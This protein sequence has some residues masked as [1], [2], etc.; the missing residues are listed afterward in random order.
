MVLVGAT[1][2][3]GRALMERTI[4]VRGIRLAAIAR[5]RIPLPT[6]ARMEMFVADT[7]HWAETMQALRPAV[8]VCALGTTW[9][10]AGKDEAAFRAVDEELVLHVARMA[11]EAGVRQFILVSSAGADR[12]SRHLYLRVKG[13][14][15]DAL[16]KLR[17]SRL[18]ILRPGLLKGKRLDDPRLG[19]RLAM[20]ASPLLDLALHGRYRNFRSIEA[21]QLADVI[22]QLTHERAGGRFVHDYDALL[23]ALRR[24]PRG[25]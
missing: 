22:L 16:A 19:E 11:K 5:R 21:T 15:E 3:V 13:E 20:L 10:K 25:G 1:G 12:M 23:R 4:G 9:H 14:T 7:G 18:D 24:G 8:V 17:F 2:L 6:G